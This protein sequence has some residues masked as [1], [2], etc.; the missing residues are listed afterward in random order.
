MKRSSS[1]RRRIA[2]FT[3]MEVMAA[4]AIT[5]MMG[6]VIAASF[7]TLF[8]AKE[9][10]EAQE[11][12]YRMLRTAMD[13]I[14][15]E[16][17]CA[18]VSDRYDPKRYRDQN[19][20]PSN[21]I[22]EKDR[23][24]FT[25]FAH[26]RM[27]LDAKESDEMVVEYK[28]KASPDPEAKGRHDLVRRENIEIGEHME[29]GG[30]E[31]S[32]FEDVKSVQF[33]Y[34]DSDRKVDSSHAGEGHA[35]RQGRERQRGEVPD[36]DTHRTQRGVR[37]V[38]MRSPSPRRSHPFDRQRGVAL[39][40]VIIAIAILA[41][42]ATE[43]AYN[44]RVDLEMATNQRDELKAYYMAKSGLGM[45][46][47]LLRFQH[48]LDGMGAIPGLSQL[49]GGAGGLGGL[50]GGGGAATST[51]GST[52]T[53]FTPTSFN[54]QLWRLAKVDCHMMRGVTGGIEDNPKRK[55]ETLA[56][57]GEFRGCFQTEFVDEEQKLNM[58][59]LDSPSMQAFPVAMRTYSLFTD[60]RFD[61]LYQKEDSHGI[62]VTPTDTMIAIRDYIDEDDTQS[63]FNPLGQPTVFANGFTDE[64]SAYDRYTPRYRPKNAHFDSL[65]E[66]YRVHGV[67]DRFM[68]AFRDRLTV[69]PD[70][71]SGININTDDPMLLYLAVQ[72]VADPTHPDPRLTDPLFME[73]II[74]Q[75]RM[76]RSMSFLGMGVQDFVTLVQSLGVTVGRTLTT[77]GNTNQVLSDHSSTYRIRVT[78]E[79]GN[80]HK[81]LTAVVR[82]NDGLG[83]LVY[84]REE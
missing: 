42:V 83:S 39:L 51:A 84:Y 13:R 44:S 43:F 53:A 24:L 67:N 69:Y 78:G 72:S 26:Q 55:P 48:Q 3:L 52:G 34:W 35:D 14:M 22:G 77:P 75:I 36:P 66:L 49:L 5:A 65:D 68:A 18:Y 9:E 54:I 20:R 19:D 27:A 79:A 46:R 25:T 82:L 81:T 17:S 76:A 61:F 80:V 40:M 32:V 8:H 50:L 12:R 16:I 21:F 71:N 47:L 60:K 2:G 70:I 37:Q 64:A 38:L 10:I 15:R 57:L 31:D 73:G 29:R 11:E 59:K 45:A 6:G 4:V 33:L 74:R 28:V 63:A 62:K 1:Q 23:L 7:S 56:H 30:Q 41:T 58:N